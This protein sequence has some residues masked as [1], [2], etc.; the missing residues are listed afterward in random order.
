MAGGSSTSHWSIARQPAWS[1]KQQATGEPQF[2]QL[3]WQFL[4]DFYWYFMDYLCES[5]IILVFGILGKVYEV[6]PWLRLIWILDLQSL[7]QCRY[8]PASPHTG[9]KYA[10][11]SVLHLHC[12]YTTLYLYC[13]YTV[14]SLHLYCIYTVTTMH[15][16]CICTTCIRIETSECQ[17]TV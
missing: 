6:R 12:N 16:Y 4:V 9:T 10:A 17:Q 3:N 13:I 5:S 2:F 15:L 14:A 7:S 8:L 1:I 11:S